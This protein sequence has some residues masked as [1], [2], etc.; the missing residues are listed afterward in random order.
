MSVH[1]FVTEANRRAHTRV[2]VPRGA[3]V[4]AKLHPDGIRGDVLSAYVR[5]VSPGGVNV[6]LRDRPIYPLRPGQNF[7]AHIDY[8]GFAVE[9]PCAVVRHSDVQVSL[10][11]PFD[12]PDLADPD[13]LRL[14]TLLMRVCTESID[15]VRP[16]DFAGLR[17]PPIYRHYHQP[18]YL[19]MRIQRERPAWWQIVFLGLAVAW[20]EEGGVTAATVPQRALTS[21][22]QA[23]ALELSRSLLK[24]CADAAPID[25]DDF[26]F[27]LDTLPSSGR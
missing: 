14:W 2:V 21:G 22:A 16:E 9:I 1:P 18:G 24:R 20:T 4:T 11:Y 8:E 19:D 7:R 23:A 27:A 3:V 13:Q 5:D 17:F 26:L 25:D 6:R 15:V 12:A 10:R